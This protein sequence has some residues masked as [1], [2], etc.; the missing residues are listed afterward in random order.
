MK[1]RERKIDPL[2]LLCTPTQIKPATQ[3]KILTGN[4]THD[5]FCCTEWQSNPLS[6]QGCFTYFC[7]HYWLL[8]YVPW[9]KIE[10]TTWVYWSNA[11]TNWS[12][13]PW[14]EKWKS[15]L[16]IYW[17]IPNSDGDSGKWV[18]AWLI[19]RSELWKSLNASIGLSLRSL[20]SSLRLRPGD[21]TG[22]VAPGTLKRFVTCKLLIVL[23]SDPWNL[24]LF[25][26]QNGNSYLLWL[27]LFAIIIIL[28]TQLKYMSK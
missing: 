17:Y 20:C 7:V 24:C 21:G 19:V 14:L 3:I 13:Q 5:L 27:Q 1:E 28:K 6:G 10:P 12:T 23:L 15:E 11:L 8:L 16:D 2:P 25:V 22:K 4:W 18:K 9:L 26:S